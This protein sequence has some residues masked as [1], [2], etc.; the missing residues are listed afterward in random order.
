MLPGVTADR[1]IALDAWSNDRVKRL[2]R[3]RER[4]GTESTG[5]RRAALFT[6][7]FFS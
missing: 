5:Y 2:K 7:F 3:E 4:T 1:R 6:L